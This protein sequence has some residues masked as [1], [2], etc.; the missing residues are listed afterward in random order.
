MKVVSHNELK[1]IIKIAYKRKIFLI[2]HGTMGKEESI[3][4]ETGKE[5]AKE[6]KRE[7]VEWNKV[8]DKEKLFEHPERYF[9]VVNPLPYVE[10]KGEKYYDISGGLNI[11]IGLPVI[12]KNNTI[13]WKI[14]KVLEWFTL[15]NSAGIIFFDEIDSSLKLLARVILLMRER[16]IHEKP[17]SDKVIIITT[18]KRIENLPALPF[19]CIELKKR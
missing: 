1:Q 8:R 2:V 5:I 17:F 13:I 9:V 7:Y 19:M 10:F 4:K 3:I 11:L 18:L 14:S 16:K 15:P 6:M 12:S